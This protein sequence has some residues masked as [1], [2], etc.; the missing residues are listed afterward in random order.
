MSAE[1]RLR[2]KNYLWQYKRLESELKTLTEEIEALE[3]QRDSITVKMDGMPR[4]TGVSD[5]TATLAVKTADLL[6]ESI[7]LRS[8]ATDKR[9][10]IV[11]RIMALKN[12]YQSRILY[13]HFVQGETIE[14]I[15]EDI[16][17]SL[18]HTHRIYADA[19]EKI[20]EELEKND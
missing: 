10:E 5:K 13:L 17:V 9:K 19:L 14:T 15:A 6:M 7:E 2:A 18:R 3:E 4:G 16:N 11:E 8:R 20:G 1:L 12:R